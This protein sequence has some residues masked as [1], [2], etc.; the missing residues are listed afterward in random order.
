MKSKVSYTCSSC[1]GQ[2]DEHCEACDQ[3]SMAVSS[4]SHCHCRMLEED[5]NLFKLE[6]SLKKKCAEMQDFWSNTFEKVIDEFMQPC[7]EGVIAKLRHF[8]THCPKVDDFVK[9]CVKKLSWTEEYALEKILPLISRWQVRN[10]TSKIIKPLQIV[11]PRTLAGTPS[12]SLKWEWIDLKPELAPENFESC[13]PAIYLTEFCPELIQEFEEKKKKPKKL[14]RKKV[15]K[16]TEEKS[17]KITAFFK[18]NKQPSKPKNAQVQKLQRA[19]IQAENLSILTDEEENLPDN[20]SFLIDDIL[21]HKLKRNLSIEQPK[22]VL[23]TSTPVNREPSCKKL[24]TPS[25]VS[26]PSEILQTETESKNEE[27]FEDSFDRMCNVKSKH[28]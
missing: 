25:K 17:Q 27:D 6:E 10:A 18:E 14:T 19:E 12:F 13:E 2:E 3:W 4:W 7:D 1:T 22:Q 28:F 15:P 24:I 23:M 9:I 21:S 16:A 5:K 11:K 26:F 20:L 8:Q